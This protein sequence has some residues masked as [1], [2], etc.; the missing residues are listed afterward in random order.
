MSSLCGSFGVCVFVV[1]LVLSILP[2][3]CLRRRWPV[4][5]RRHVVVDDGAS[6]YRRRE[7]TTKKMIIWTCGP[8]GLGLSWFPPLQ[9]TI[10]ATC[11]T[12]GSSQAY[13]SLPGARLKSS[14]GTRLACVDTA[15]LRI[16]S[17]SR[18]CLMMN[19][20]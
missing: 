18:P 6:S 7:T 9:V 13:L 15:R 12:L 2:S 4:S 17:V 20:V 1:D 14:T 19:E 10:F 3:S 5:R 8:A 11:T 16:M